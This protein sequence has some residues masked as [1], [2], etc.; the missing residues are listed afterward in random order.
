MKI[1]VASDERASLTDHVVEWLRAQGH[2]VTLFGAL[3]GGQLTPWPQS[4][5]EL[6]EH[7]ALGDC[8]QGVLFCYTG[9]GASIAANKVPGI[10]AALCADAP[11]AQGARRWNHANVLVLSYRA[12]SETVADEILAA[13]FAAPF[14]EG[15]D[16]AMVAQL[17]E[18]ERRY[19]ESI[20]RAQDEV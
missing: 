13:W 2:D 6:A 20:M 19:A 15:E 11:T 17:A 18:I 4:S 5:V 1:A 7:V 10:R 12:T 3:A 8:E 9:T 14:G 16:A